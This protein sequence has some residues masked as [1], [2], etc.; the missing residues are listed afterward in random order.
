MEISPGFDLL[1]LVEVDHL[2]GQERQDIMDDSGRAASPLGSG[3]IVQL[4]QSPA[5]SL[6]PLFQRDPLVLH[7]ASNRT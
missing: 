7:P 4:V 1:A 5:E 2:L 6:A 3:E